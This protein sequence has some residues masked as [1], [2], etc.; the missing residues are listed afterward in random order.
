MKNLYLL[1]ALCVAFSPAAR[2]TQNDMVLDN[3]AGSV[4][5]ADANSALQALANTSK[6]G[7]RPSTSYPGQIWLDDN[8]PSVTVWTLYLYDGTDDISLGTFN[9][10]SN[11]FTPTLVDSQVT[12]AKMANMA[13]NTIK[14]NNTGG[15]AAPG[16]LTGTEVTALLSNMVGDSGTGGTKGLVPAPAAGDAAAGKFL[17]A[18]GTFAVPSNS[19][20]Q[21]S[22][23]E[24]A[25]ETVATKY[26]SPDRL[27]TAPSVAKSWGHINS[28]GSPTLLRGYNVASISGIGQGARINFTTA[29]TTTNYTVVATIRSAST[30][31]LANNLQI[32]RATSHVDISTSTSLPN[33]IEINFAIYE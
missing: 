24:I 25:A 13:S 19:I 1:I 3:A 9:I 28:S 10:T 30:G 31:A 15:S 7:T 14:G 4:F 11:V 17:K 8:T 26:I 29:M 21:A 23:V 22:T 18:D 27:K 2:A 20:T 5:R 12:N 6:G 32:T 33:N 16:D